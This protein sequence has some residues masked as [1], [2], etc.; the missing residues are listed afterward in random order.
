MNEVTTETD[1]ADQI[2]QWIEHQHFILDGR[3]SN[4]IKILAAEH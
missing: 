3:G 4:L 1:Y 2:A